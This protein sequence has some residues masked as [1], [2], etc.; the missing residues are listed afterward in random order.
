MDQAIAFIKQGD[1]TGDRILGL[2]D[3]F[4]I[5]EEGLD[6]CMKHEMTQK[7]RDLAAK[8]PTQ[9]ILGNHDEDLENYKDGLK[10]PNPISPIEIIDP[11]WDKGF[12]Y[13]LARSK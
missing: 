5:E 13:C 6:T 3:W 8:V 7:F 2:G 12:F 9:L 4:H 11:F 10:S 1:E